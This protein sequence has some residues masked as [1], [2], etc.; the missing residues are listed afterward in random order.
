MGSKKSRIVWKVRKKCSRCNKVFYIKQGE[1]S[2]R[3]FCYEC[4][5]KRNF[6]V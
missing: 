5:P 6:E 4:E 2:G 1:Y 3:L